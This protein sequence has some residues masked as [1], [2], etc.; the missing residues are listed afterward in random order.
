MTSVPTSDPSVG[1]AL[2]PGPDT[3]VLAHR[4]LRDSTDKATLSRFGDPVWHLGPGLLDDQLC[5]VSENWPRLMPDSLREG[6]TTCAWVALNTNWPAQLRP[7]LID[8]QPE[9]LTIHKWIMSMS[10]FA[11]WLDTR[12]FTRLCDVSSRDL[13]LY[14]S[15]VLALTNSTEDKR[16]LLHAVRVVWGYRDTLPDEHRLPH[17]RPWGAASADDLVG[18]KRVQ[19][20][21]NKTPRIDPVTMDA[22]LAWALRMVEDFGPDIRDA[23]REARLLLDGRHPATL[24]ARD[25]FSSG[26]LKGRLAVYVAELHRAGRGLPGTKRRERHG[27]RLGVDHQHI[28]RMV[29]S[30]GPHVKPYDGLLLS[31]AE[32]YGLE[33]ESDAYFLGP[34]TGSF[35]GAPWRDRPIGVR[36]VNQLVRYLTAACFIVICYLSGMRSGE[37]LQLRR[38]CLREDEYGGLVL[39]GRRSKG[40]DHDP[41]P[42]PEETEERAWAVVGAVAPVVRI[43]ESLSDAELLFPPSRQRTTTVRSRRKQSKPSGTMNDDIREFMGWVNAQF[44][45]RDDPA[46]P[47]DPTKDIHA[48]RFRRTLAYFV[49]RRP[50]GLAAAQAQYGHIRAKVTLGYAGDA[51]TS[52]MED[53]ALEE[54]EMVSEQVD[55]DLR[56][57]D[58]GEH[59]SGPSAQ[60]YRHRVRKSAAVFT[61]RVVIHADNAQRLLSSKHPDIHHGRG[62]TCVW[63]YE[64]AGCREEREAAGVDVHGPD[65]PLCRT[66]CVNLAYTDRDIEDKKRELTRHEAAAADPLSPRPLREREAAKAARARAVIAAHELGRHGSSRQ[67][68]AGKERLDGAQTS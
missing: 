7:G 12:G 20:R 27:G 18:V 45:G 24:A 6:F 59:V 4:P 28:A 5:P 58:D 16:R 60:E 1:A 13:G 10:P 56:A 64:T 52:W 50:G 22:L 67:K 26:S 42:D 11:A 34:I 68:Q 53:L 51:D 61:G 37:V 23:A 36:E 47:P 33:L 32:D 15:H 31:M 63:R 43:L 21:Y 66:A 2:L 40:S 25:R 38:G 46:I 54:L 30:T 29:A 3:V 48:A 9:V 55:E 62:M 49:V 44:S 14:K 19:S 35:Q 8:E 17:R 39:V 65:E 41:D 57:L